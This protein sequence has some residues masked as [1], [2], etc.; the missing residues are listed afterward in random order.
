MKLINRKATMNVQ[1]CMLAFFVALLL[2][3]TL[4]AQQETGRITGTVKD[5]SG[6]VVPG[7]VVSVR[8]V[9]TNAARSATTGVDGGYVVTNLL[10]GSYEVSAALTGFNTAKKQVAVPV[11]G[12]ASADFSLTVGA[13]ATTVTVSAAAVQVETETQ[14][15]SSVITTKQ[16]LELPTLTRNPYDLVATAGN[17]TPVDPRDSGAVRGVGYNINGQR[18]A[19]TNILLDGADNN[20]T[21]TATVG[22]SVPLDSVQEISVVSSAFTAEYGRA[23]GGVVNVA[24]KS[25]A[26]QFHGT[27]YEFNRV[28]A[29]SSNSFD[30]NAQGVPKGVFTRNQFGFSAGGPVKKDKLFFFNNTE[31][32]RIR[33]SS[34]D[35]A[36]VPTPELLAA[37]APVTQQ[38]FSTLGQLKVQPNGRIYT[39]NDIPGL[40]NATGPCASLPGTLPVWATV[41]YPVPA[42]AGGGDPQNQ[43]QSVTRIDYNLSEK[44]TIYGRY[45]VQSLDRFT[46]TISSSPYVGYDTGENIFNNN[47]LLSITH[48]FSPQLVSQSKAVYSR[49][50]DLQSLGSAPVA[51]GLYLSSANVASQ[52]LGINVA[53]AGYL[54]LTPGNAI[55]F[56]GPQNLGQLYE[57]LS[58][59]KGT[60]TFRF[61]GQYIYIRDNRAF[62]AYQEAVE[63]L[64][65]SLK[66]GMDNFLLGQLTNFAAAVDP[67]GK[68]PGQTVT[69]PVGPPDF[70]RSNR[71]ND[72]ALYAQD[73][74]RLKPR[75]T[76]N[77]GLRWE[78]YGVQHNKDPFKDSNY[79][80]GSGS[81]I[82]QQFANGSVQL[83][84]N[85]PVG[86]LWQK[87]LDNFAP[88]VGVAWD[89]FGN[90]KTSLRSGYGI[91][92]ERNFGNVTFNVI[93]NPPNYA[94]VT[95]SPSD[96]GGNLPVTLS[97][98]GPLAGSSGTKTLPVVQLRAVDPS[99]QTAYAHF[100]SVSIEREI[101]SD[102]VL[103]VEYSGSR[104]VGL[105]SI[106]RENNLGSANVFLGQTGPLSREN[107]QYSNINFRT[108]NGF[109]RYHGMVTE[110]RSQNLFNS[111]VQL[112]FNWTWSHSLDNI[113]DTFS[114]FSNDFNLGLLDPHNPSLDYGNS[115]FDV[116]HRIALS[117]VWDVPFAKNM[118]GVGN[119]ILGGWSFAPILTAHTGLPYT[120]YD[121]SNAFLQC[122]RMIMVNPGLPTAGSGNSAMVPGVPNS[123]TFLDLTPE[124]A[125]VGTYAN[126]ITGTSDFG[127]YP[128]N[129]VGRNTFRQPGAWDFN[130]GAY[131]SFKLPKEGTSLQF[132]AEL[133]NVFNHSN[134]YAVTSSA[135]I[136]ST[137]Y[138]PALK[139]A[140]GTVAER[141]N[142][143]F[144]LKF[145]F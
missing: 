25:G 49:L 15:L 138:I 128:S 140:T 89:V 46:G 24:T 114:G 61:G 43:Y 38:F 88:R 129:M 68:F 118:K 103:S 80:L 62:G 48:I 95:L 136:S 133:Y 97:N 60:H 22:Q 79:Y 131:K 56:G 51:P 54:P 81:T 13:I 55:P 4:L 143:Q 7:A 124:L 59:N 132:R 8:S 121:C 40:C 83:A 116:R 137:A 69:L 32:Y 112:K 1:R 64:G 34:T 20:D 106:N 2:A 99:M 67:Q 93:Q 92:Y 57:D 84:P 35:T 33:S 120:I 11:G 12:I 126:P 113:S 63:V 104:G 82:D 26:N 102:T 74:W 78:Y 142:I 109:S 3:G 111:G 107:P 91:S 53:L 105:Y 125:G 47:G 94:V 27:A 14:T 36:L 28:S 31:W 23:G 123:F 115:D 30:N 72:F 66:Q 9:A 44:T 18:S 70:T 19:S 5:Q 87:D 21:F 71:Y 145:L 77:L 6:A 39:K 52:I 41:N 50:N 86:G 122:N 98:F 139:G 73:T 135:D 96:V 117:G 75:F 76:V 90:G 10:P 45:A 100:W 65:T 17:I 101:A 127:P 119:Q 108:D 130:L 85:S 42:D 134:L 29:L 144:A 16:V 37:A 110:L 58:W 141:R